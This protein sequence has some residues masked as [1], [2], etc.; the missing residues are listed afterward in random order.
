MESFVSRIEDDLS[1]AFKSA[2]TESDGGFKK[3]IE[4]WKASFKDMLAELAY[5][6]FAR[7]ILMSVVG[8]AGGSGTA[9]ASSLL[10]GSASTGSGGSILGSLGILVAAFEWRPLFSNS[11]K[12]WGK[13]WRK[14]ICWWR[15]F[16]WSGISWSSSVRKLGL[17]YARKYGA[18]LFGLGGGVGGSVGGTLGS[19]VGGAF[20]PVG[21]VA[22]GFLGSAVGGL[23]GGGKPKRNTLGGLVN[24][25]Q[26]GL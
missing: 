1:G 14:S 25:D 5:Q 8:V 19:L 18:Q 15:S 13:A 7:P 21:A 12:F 10:G 4:G 26:S 16:I 17:R 24:V 11:W 9:S 2:F 3:M 23:F 20:G 6:A 22:G